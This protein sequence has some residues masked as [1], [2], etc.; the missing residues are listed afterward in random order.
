VAPILRIADLVL[1]ITNCLIQ[2]LL[3]WDY[4]SPM[5]SISFVFLRVLCGKWFWFSPG[6]LLPSRALQGFGRGKNIAQ[7]AIKRLQAF[8]NPHL[9]KS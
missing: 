2:E 6:T 4:R 8:R 1:L 5:S 7:T 3:I 9:P